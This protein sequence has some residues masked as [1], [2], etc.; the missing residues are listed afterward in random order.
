METCGPGPSA[1]RKM[2]GRPS[3][4]SLVQVTRGLDQQGWGYNLQERLL[5]GRAGL[6]VDLA[7]RA[8]V[9]S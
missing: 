2:E 5:S 4:A 1:A 3:W 7:Q 8:A 9:W 6:G